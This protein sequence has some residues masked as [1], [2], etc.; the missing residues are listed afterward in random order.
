MK[1]QRIGVLSLIAAFAIVTSMLTATAAVVG[2]PST[3]PTFQKGVLADQHGMTLYVSRKDG[4]SQWAYDGQP[5]YGFSN[6][7][8][9]GQQNGDG[10]KGLW[11]VIKASS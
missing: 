4:G 8:A 3:M 6:D 7:T 11:K 2:T 1:T 5:L 10:F 9:P